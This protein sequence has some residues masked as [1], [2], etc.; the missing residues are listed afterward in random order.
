MH[1]VRFAGFNGSYDGEQSLCFGNESH[2][3]GSSEPHVWTSG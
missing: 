3:A 2:H 1:N